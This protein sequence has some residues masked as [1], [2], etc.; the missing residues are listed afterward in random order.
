MDFLDELKQESETSKQQ[1]LEEEKA[2]SEKT[3]MFQSQAYPVMTTVYKYLKKLAE[4]LGSASLTIRR[5]YE[6]EGL[7]TLRALT[8]GNYIIKVDDYDRPTEVTLTLECTGERPITLTQKENLRV[9]RSKEYLWGH[10]LRFTPLNRSTKTGKALEGM[11]F[12]MEPRVPITIKF[13]ASQET[14]DVRLDI[15]NLERLGVMGRNIRFEIL[16]E[17]FLEEIA[18]AIA[19]KDNQLNKLM[20]F[21]V[22]DATRTKLRAQL[23]KAREQESTQKQEEPAAEEAADPDKTS[24]KKLF[25]KVKT[26][27]T[28]EL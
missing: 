17:R 27:L 4:T 18:K 12:K 9:E 13:K 6:V 11:D 28:K 22:D 20:G 15:K 14:S 26:I 24:S 1:A 21:D 5:D 8:Q 23:D 7:G 16:N 25:S 3:Q 2:A 19:K 10:G